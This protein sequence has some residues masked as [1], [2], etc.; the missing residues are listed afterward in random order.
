MEKEKYRI[1]DIYTN[2]MGGAIAVTKDEILV[3]DYI[4]GEAPFTVFNR[5]V[6]SI[7]SYDYDDDK[8]ESINE[9]YNNALAEAME[10]SEDISDIP[11]DLKKEIIDNK[12]LDADWL[13]P[14]E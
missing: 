12:L 1:D 9:L 11:D 7:K 13:E 2:E 8:P 3:F 4:E 5:K 14:I 10:D 6:K